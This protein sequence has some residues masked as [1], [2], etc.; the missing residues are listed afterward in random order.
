[1]KFAPSIPFLIGLSISAGML[2]AG[3]GFHNGA[4]EYCTTSAYGLPLPWRIDNCL[5]DGNGGLTEFPIWT[6]CLN[7]M[8]GLI[9]AKLIASWLLCL[10][11]KKERTPQAT[12]PQFTSHRP[13]KPITYGSKPR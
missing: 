12:K 3:A 4:F 5:C 13:A 9:V 8:V 2:Y 10:Q 1:M 11:P 7:V 6:A